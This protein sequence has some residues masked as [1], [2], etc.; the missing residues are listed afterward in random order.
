MGTYHFSGST[1]TKSVLLQ[2]TKSDNSNMGSLLSKSN[3]LNSQAVI[4]PPIP[5]PSVPASHAFLMFNIGLQFVNLSQDIWREP[6]AFHSV[7]GYYY[8]KNTSP[9]THTKVAQVLFL[10]AATFSYTRGF[11]AIFTR[12]SSR[13]RK[14]SDFFGFVLFLSNLILNLKYLLPLEKKVGHFWVSA[15]LQSGP[16]QPPAKEE[17][18]RVALRNG[19]LL[20]LGLLVL[21]MVQQSISWKNGTIEI[22]KGLTTIPAVAKK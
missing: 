6:G 22:V 9:A 4:V 10:L 1:R 20:N 18:I 11:L 16:F 21:M 17:E 12:D 8:R 7:A 3:G 5:I 13:K 19:H 14:V 15:K 2:T